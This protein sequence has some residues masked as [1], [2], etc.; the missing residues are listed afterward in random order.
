MDRQAGYH[1][2]RAQ[3][4]LRLSMDRALRD[5]GLTMAQYALLR[6]LENQ[7]DASNA[8]LSRACFVTPQ[9]MIQTLRGLETAGLVSRRRHSSDRRVMTTTLTASGCA[10]LSAAHRV[11]DALESRML[12][13]IPEGDQQHLVSMLE[14]ITANLAEDPSGAT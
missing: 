4:A 7:P 11:V 6:A 8:D 10:Q 5:V 3:H 2:K 14:A 9:T 12:T 13:G 1:V